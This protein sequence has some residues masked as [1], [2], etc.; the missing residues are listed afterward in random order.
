[1]I[2]RLAAALAS[3]L[4]RAYHPDQRHSDHDKSVH[5]KVKPPFPNSDY[6]SDACFFARNL[7]MVDIFWRNDPIVTFQRMPESLSALFKMVSLTAAKTR[8]M[9][10]VSVACVR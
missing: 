5:D 9:L 6:A 7:Q 3:H 10:E 4:E 8:R 2:K 1:M